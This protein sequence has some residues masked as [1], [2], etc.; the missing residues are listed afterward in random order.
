MICLLEEAVPLPTKETVE[1]NNEITPQMKMEIYKELHGS[2]SPKDILTKKIAVIIDN[3]MSMNK[4][5]SMLKDISEKSGSQRVLKDLIF[6]EF[7]EE[8]S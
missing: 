2:Y 4:I 8:F 5:S 6:N 7:I 1:E 3:K